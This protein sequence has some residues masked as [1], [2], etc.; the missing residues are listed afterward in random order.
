MLNLVRWIKL[1]VWETCKDCNKWAA[2]DPTKNLVFPRAATPRFLYF[3]TKYLVMTFS[4]L[5]WGI[6]DANRVPR[7]KTVKCQ[8]LGDKD[9]PLQAPLNANL[10]WNDSKNSLIFIAVSFMLTWARSKIP[11]VSQCAQLI[12]RHDYDS[13][14]EYYYGYEAYE[15]KNC[16]E[17]SWNSKPLRKSE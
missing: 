15:I 2:L 5:L 6:D 14:T 16:P 1:F 17:K 10:H 3:I 8:C 4:M 12:I 13:A 7:G 9:I 11:Q